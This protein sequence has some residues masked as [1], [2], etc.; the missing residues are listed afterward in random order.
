MDADSDRTLE[1]QREKLA[2][3]DT[4]GNMNGACLIKG[5]AGAGVAGTV[6]Q[7]KWG[8]WHVTD[9]AIWAQDSR[10]GGASY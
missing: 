1:V 5:L 8:L 2:K 6:E 7:M 10:K 9:W 3:K 4:K